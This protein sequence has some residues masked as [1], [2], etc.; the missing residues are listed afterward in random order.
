MQIWGNICPV[1]NVCEID[2]KFTVKL[3]WHL[4]NNDLT[5]NRKTF[6][7]FLSLLLRNYKQDVEDEFDPN[8]GKLIT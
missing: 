1:F 7:S 3:N 8:L 4:L 5:L 6:K 2:I